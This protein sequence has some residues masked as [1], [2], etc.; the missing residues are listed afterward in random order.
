MLNRLETQYTFYNCCCKKAAFSVNNTLPLLKIFKLFKHTKALFK[1]VQY[2]R[3]RLHKCQ[4][5][6]EMSKNAAIGGVFLEIS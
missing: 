5:L 2:L 6:N 4:S 1:G 3:K